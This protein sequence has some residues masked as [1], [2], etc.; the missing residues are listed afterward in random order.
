MTCVPAFVPTHTKYSYSNEWLKSRAFLQTS[1]R[2]C[3]QTE[4]EFAGIS[5]SKLRVK[6]RKRTRGKRAG[7]RKQR[8]IPVLTSF[9]P[10]HNTCPVYCQCF[11]SV[12]KNSKINTHNLLLVP[13]EANEN[14]EC[15]NSLKVWY[16]NAQSARP[17]VHLLNDAILDSDSDIAFITETWFYTTGDEFYIEQ[18]RPPGYAKPV[19]IPRTSGQIGGGLL[20]LCKDGMKFKNRTITDFNSFE[21]CE[22]IFSFDKKDT[23]FVCIYR[24]TPS[25]EN[26]LTPRIFLDDFTLFLDFYS[27]NCC[28]LVII[29][30]FNL[31]FD[32]DTETYAQEMKMLLS[33]RSFTQIIDKPTQRKNHIL[34]WVVAKENDNTIHNVDVVDKCISDHYVITFH[35]N[36][37]KP[38]PLKKLVTSRDIKNINEGTFSSEIIKSFSTIEGDVDKLAI[39]YDSELKR[40][41]DVHAPLKSR[42]VSTRKPAPWLNSEVKSAKKE[43]RKAER[44]WRHSNLTVHRQIFQSLNIFVNRLIQ[45]LKKVFYCDK[46][47]SCKS[48]KALFSISNEL[49]GKSN[50]K[51]FPDN[52]SKADQPDV[53]CEFFK[54][55][56]FKI[57][58]ELANCDVE[59]IF[60]DFNGSI[61]KDFSIV[62]TDFVK[63]IILKS[64]P[65]TC[66]LDPMPTFLLQQHIDH[67]VDYITCIVNKSLSTGV[68][69]TICKSAIIQ[70]NIKKPNLDP[71]ELK[72]YRPVSNLSF[73]SKVLEKIV[74]YQLQ[75]HLNSNNL[76]EIFQSAYK[77]GHSTETALLKIICDLL[78]A[79]DEGKVSILTL[80]DLSAAFDTID[81]EIMLNRLSKTFGIQGTVLKWFKSY[82]VGRSFS[83]LIADLKSSSSTLEFGVPQGSVLGPI[84]YIMY[85]YPLGQIIRRYENLSFHMYADDTQLYG[86]VFLEN[87]P[88]LLDCMQRC[89]SEVN[90]WMRSNK[91]KMNNDKTEILPCSTVHKLSSLENTTLEIDNETVPFSNKVKNLGVIID[92][93]LSLNAQ[94]NSI[95]KA[96]YF[97]IRKIGQLR[98]FLDIE[99]IKVL[100]SSF[101]L[102]RLDY[103]NSLLSGASSE[104]INKLQRVQNNAARLVFKVSKRSHITPFLKELHWLPIRARIEYKIAT[105]CFNAL[106]GTSPLYIS[107]LIQEYKP[108]RNLRS[109]QANRLSVPTSKLKTYGDRAFSFT[110]PHVWNSLPEHLRKTSDFKKFKKDLKTHIF[111]KYF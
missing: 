108:I 19:S 96:A 44:R 30:D 80:L 95:C 81:H 37:S 102:S 105:I 26:R 66:L 99:S 12:L 39:Y 41:L 3:L 107:D 87:M 64:S 36:V 40:I 50:V 82:L 7:R 59:P 1:I 15:S 5:I 4:L 109:S 104:N 34:D 21:A 88:D 35:M 33:N 90:I 65:K 106:N 84:L 8:A 79:T 98:S 62:D 24:P 86:S 69:P 46:I 43:R 31:H 22:F 56:V 72:N 89:V 92:S 111:N 100:C 58:N 16:T 97:Q 25:E 45:S 49:T 67:I 6:T 63:N 85:T 9:S 68:F 53:F 83:V 27:F 54:S 78:N 23:I 73:L 2:H 13:I 20:M 42:K 101:V 14:L 17:K 11:P 29:G 76:N 93:S 110:A 94:I 38:K 70:P 74:L 32:N 61:F 71:N 91:L 103:C 28:D 18:L 57:R 77:A 10:L 48:T 52:I 51:V 60:D 55:K 47:Q 75:K